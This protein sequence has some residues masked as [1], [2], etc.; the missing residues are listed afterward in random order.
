MH[1]HGTFRLEQLPQ[2]TVMCFVA[3]SDEPRHPGNPFSLC[4]FFEQFLAARGTSWQA[5][6]GK[7]DDRAPRDLENFV[8]QHIKDR[9]MHEQIRQALNEVH[10]LNLLS[11]TKRRQ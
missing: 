10:G 4:A 9:Q 11:P 1:G 3:W 7:A 2:G 6:R 8:N 5:L